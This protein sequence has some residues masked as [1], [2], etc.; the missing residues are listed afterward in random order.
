ML[1]RGQQGLLPLEQVIQA[2]HHFSGEYP[3]ARMFLW[4]GTDSQSHGN[5]TRVVTSITGYRERKGARSYQYAQVLNRRLPLGEKL[6]YETHMSIEVIG[7]LRQALKSHLLC[8]ELE[9]H[10]DGGEN[11]LSRLH[12]PRVV[13]W[14]ESLAPIYQYT[15]RTK[16]FAVGATRVADRYSK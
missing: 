12:L 15:V 11:G 2:L 6:D 16:P 13:G 9:L 4:I 8:W 14:A 3:D 7:K 1:F 10:I 5:T